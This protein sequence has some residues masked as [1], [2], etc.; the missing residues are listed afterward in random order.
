VASIST[1]SGNHGKKSV[2]S[3]IPLIPF[4]D[5]LLCC[6]MFLLVTAV[7]N[8]L[9]S[10][11]AHLDSPGRPVSEIDLPAPSELPLVVLIDGEG[12]RLSTELGDET[13]IPLSASGDHDTLALQEALRE[14][15][16]IVPNE[17]RV[18]LSADDGIQYAQVVEAM[19]I[20]S[21]SGYPSVTLADG[22]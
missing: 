5:L 16:R 10:L 13:R 14:R 11:E 1:G 22:R 21:G 7:W 3:E 20:F 8:R 19:D 2:D 12:Y 15:H 18:V 4:I 17:G 6:I 9:A